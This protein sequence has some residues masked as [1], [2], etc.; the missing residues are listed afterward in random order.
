M[1]RFLPTTPVRLLLDKNGND[2]AANV[3]FDTFN[4]QLNAVGKQTASK[5]ASALQSSVH[6]M[7]ETANKLAQSQLDTLKQSA[8]ESVNTNL[9]DELA[10]LK[11]LKQ[12]NPNVREDELFY[13]EKQKSQL[14]EHVEK[15]ELKLDAIRL[16]VVSH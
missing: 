11:S 15:A 16:I 13:L 8:K 3:A 7:I 12:L 6:P 5:L 2:L 10:R 14:L 1:G 9:D 4:Q